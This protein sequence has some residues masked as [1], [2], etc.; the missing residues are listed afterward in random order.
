VGEAIDILDTAVW[1]HGVVCDSCPARGLSVYFLGAPERRWVSDPQLL[2]PGKLWAAGGWHPRLL[3][4]LPGN[5]VR[6][7]P[8]AARQP[9]ARQ[10]AAAAPKPQPDAAA[11]R[12]GP[13]KPS[14]AAAAKQNPKV[15]A[16]PVENDDKETVLVRRS[17]RERQSRLTLVR[18]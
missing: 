4:P 2:R 12:A 13:A 1:W 8:P 17:A 18:R 9:P 11:K 3:P 14:A 10:Q 15:K 7:P 16:E 5:L 6:R